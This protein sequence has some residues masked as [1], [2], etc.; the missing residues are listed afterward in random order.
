MEK[1]VIW[2]MVSVQYFTLVQYLSNSN[3]RHNKKPEPLW[4]LG[5]YSVKMAKKTGRSNREEKLPIFHYT[6]PTILKV[7]TNTSVFSLCQLKRPLTHCQTAS[8]TCW[9]TC[10]HE[11]FQPQDEYLIDHQCLI[12][13]LLFELWG[14]RPYIQHPIVTTSDWKEKEKHQKKQQLLPLHISQWYYY[15]LKQSLFD[16]ETEENVRVLAESQTGTHTAQMLTFFFFGKAQHDKWTFS[17]GQRLQYG[18]FIML[19]VR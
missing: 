9:Q 10:V 17:R 1:S 8:L 18:L 12:V 19:E 16:R 6:S 11:L 2:N 4:L 3:L 15:Y 5:C 13:R 14:C 7:L